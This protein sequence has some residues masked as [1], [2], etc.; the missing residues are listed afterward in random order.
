MTETTTN[1]PVASSAPAA[2]NANPSPKKKKTVAAKPKAAPTHPKYAEMIKAALKALNDRG[3]SSRAAIL[4]FVLANYS[5]DPAQAN[6]HLKLALKN[7]VKAKVLK[8]TKGSGASGS[9]K[10]ASNV[11]SAATKKKSAKP[12]KAKPATGTATSATKKRPRSKSAGGK[13]AKK[14]ATAAN[15]N[16]TVAAPT[17]SGANTSAAKPKKVKATKAAKPRSSAK[18]K[19]AGAAKVAKPKQ[20]NVCSTDSLFG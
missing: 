19:V 16:S 3:G 12:K 10:L 15:N 13:P 1:A 11:E 2:N 9:F 5:L 18:P 4:K 6:Q 20:G 8:Q 14:L 17:D 7:G